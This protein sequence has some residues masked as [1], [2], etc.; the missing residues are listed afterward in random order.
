MSKRYVCQM[1]NLKED[2]IERYFEDLLKDNLM[3]V[4]IARD[5]HTHQHM[6]YGFLEFPS[7]EHM[8]HAIKVCSVKL[9]HIRIHQV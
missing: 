3:H 8:Q 5:S 7:Q 2:H 6:G 4:W 1:N 9:P